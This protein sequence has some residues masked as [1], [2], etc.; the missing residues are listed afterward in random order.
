MSLRK[1]T[2]IIVVVSV[3]GLILFVSA[4]SSFILGIGFNYLENKGVQSSIDSARA[5]IQTE[6]YSLDIATGDWAPRNAAYDF[7]GGTNDK[8]VE[9]NISKETFENFRLNL[10]LIADTTGKIVYS[11]GFDLD[12]SQMTPLSADLL[13]QIKANP[14]LFKHDSPS[15]LTSGL[16]NLPGGTMLVSSRPVVTNEYAGPIRGSMI[17]GR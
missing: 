13:N 2:F 12:K 4:T 8:Y 7:L 5:A 9:D 1:K 17:F 14:V 15:S 16:L 10:I 6:N 11:Q 3:I